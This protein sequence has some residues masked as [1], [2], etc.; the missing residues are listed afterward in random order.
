MFDSQVH[1]ALV[2]VFV[3]VQSACALSSCFFCVGCAYANRYR[4]LH[5]FPLSYCVNDVLAIWLLM[6][7]KGAQSHVVWTI[8][9]FSVFVRHHNWPLSI[10]K[11][12]GV[13]TMNRCSRVYFV[14]FAIWNGTVADF[15]VLVLECLSVV[16]AGGFNFNFHS[17]FL[18]LKGHWTWII[19]SVVWRIKLRIL[20]WHVFTMAALT[21][22]CTLPNEFHFEISNFK[23]FFRGGF[24][25]PH[26][27]L[28][29]SCS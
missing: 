7:I 4:Q 5:S 16:T 3:F 28:K 15:A 12:A 27:S 9:E 10:G 29:K 18:F 26:G 20:W 25:S 14:A 23:G 19:S 22:A 17:V 24:W 8:S 21:S 1:G 6:F 11:S 2:W 13:S